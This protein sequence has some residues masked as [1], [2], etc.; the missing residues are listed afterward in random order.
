M[1]REASEAGFS[2]SEGSKATVRIGDRIPIPNTTFNAAPTVGGT[3]G[4]PITSFT[5]QNV[6]INIDLEPR[7]HH[8]REITLK[9]KIEISA[10]SASSGIV[11]EVNRQIGS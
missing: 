11:D 1:P 10:L 5:Y 7:V 3:I 2:V 9:G 6:G 4:V 8:N